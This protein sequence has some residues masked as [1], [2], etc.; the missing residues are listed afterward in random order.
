[1]GKKLD[2]IVKIG[3]LT[4]A[5]GAL[6]VSA[7]IGATWVGLYITD[8]VRA[9]IDYNKLI[10]DKITQLVEQDFPEETEFKYRRVHRDLCLQPKKRECQWEQYKVIFSDDSSASY[11]LELCEKADQPGY[12]KEAHYRK[13]VRGSIQL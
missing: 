6:G 8:G 12:F 13:E 4:P 1:M 10:D 7:L 11:C 2:L 9:N 3:L 5:V